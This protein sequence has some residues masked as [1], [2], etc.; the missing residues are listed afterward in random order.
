MVPG[1]D[2]ASVHELRCKVMNPRPAA[3]ESEVAER[4][5]SWV[6][7]A[8]ILKRIDTATD[9]LPGQYVLSA[10]Q[11]RLTDWAKHR[12]DLNCSKTEEP[13]TQGVIGMVRAHAHIQ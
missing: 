2:Q 3:K 9:K 4:L 5:E 12:V 13:T 8:M 6:G 11:M 7:Y 10:L 1:K